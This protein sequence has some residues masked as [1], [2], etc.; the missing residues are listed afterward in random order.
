[1]E[2]RTVHYR[3]SSRKKTTPA[4]APV[5]TSNNA[6][7]QAMQNAHGSNDGD[8]HGALL[9]GRVAM[10]VDL[11]TD[12]NATGVTIDDSVC[13]LFDFPAA[14][15]AMMSKYPAPEGAPKSSKYPHSFTFIPKEG[16]LPAGTLF[17][18]KSPGRL[19]PMG[20]SRV[21]VRSLARLSV[22]IVPEK[23]SREG[24]TGK[25]VADVHVDERGQVTRVDIVDAKHP[26]M[27]HALRAALEACEFKPF[28]TNGKATPVI[29]RREEYFYNKTQNKE[30]VYAEY[31]TGR[32][33]VM[34]ER[35]VF[36]LNLD[37]PPDVA[38]EP[39]VGL[40]SPIQPLVRTKALFP[41]SVKAESK[42]TA[43]IEFVI[44]EAGRVRSPKIVSASHAAF[45]YSA[46]QALST[47]GFLGP[48]KDGRPLCVTTTVEYTFEKGSETKT[49]L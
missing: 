13:P 43:V 19:S 2:T 38:V 29:L 39:A 20:G 18:I 14:C 32:R 6:Y 34:E 31:Q 12:G 30:A 16:L 26:A 5:Y 45:G 47:W 11:D 25:A 27:G 37:L 9:S 23:S 1:M 33:T 22:P 17:E 10:T 42:G 41:L 8:H 15:A 44:D 28:K 48:E 24:K 35:T 49:S 40:D 21:T 4:R 46:V 36:S 7:R 3:Y